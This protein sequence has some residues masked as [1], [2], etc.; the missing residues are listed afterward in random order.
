MAYCDQDTV[1]GYTCTRRATWEQDQPRHRVERGLSAEVERYCTRHANIYLV[2]RGE[3]SGRSRRIDA[4]GN[5]VR[6]NR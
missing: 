2:P 3:A 4:N 6:G 1:A 5:V